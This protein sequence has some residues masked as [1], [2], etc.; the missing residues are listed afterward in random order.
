ML[1]E[2]DGF[3]D[4][5][6]HLGE[7]ATQHHDTGGHG[8]DENGGDTVHHGAAVHGGDGGDGGS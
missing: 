2:R 7:A 6:K 3:H 4:I 1:T 8:G 5:V